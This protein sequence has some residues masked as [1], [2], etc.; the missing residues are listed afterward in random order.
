MQQTTLCTK[1][2]KETHMKEYISVVN[3]S[4]RFWQPCCGQDWNPDTPI[5]ILYCKIIVHA[6][7]MLDMRYFPVSF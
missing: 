7:D 3:I 6:V 2:I 5:I 4:L 1:D